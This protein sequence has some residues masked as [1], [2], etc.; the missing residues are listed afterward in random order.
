MDLPVYAK[1]IYVAKKLFDYAESYGYYFNLLDI[2]GGFPGDK[3]TN[4]VEVRIIIIKIYLQRLQIILFTVV[5][6]NK[7]STRQTFPNR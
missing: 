7:C 4:M 1:A 3:G 5:W 2:G 6:N